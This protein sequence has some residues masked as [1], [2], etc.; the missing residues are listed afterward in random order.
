M[1]TTIKKIAI[2]GAGVIGTG[3]TLRFLVH[4]KE[5]YVYDPSI[6]QTKFL[7]KEYDRTKLILKKFYKS[8]KISFKNIHFTESIKE[9]V[10]QVD[11]VQENVPENEKIKKK[12]YKR[13]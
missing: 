6:S 11:L 7:K 5:I 9:A 3:W 2:I 8:K 12:Y 4:S 13:N 10:K 1:S